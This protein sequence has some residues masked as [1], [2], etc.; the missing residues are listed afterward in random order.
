MLYLILSIFCSVLVGVVFKLARPKGFDAF[1]VI[2][3]NYA[4]AL[5]LC[6]LVFKPEVSAFEAG[7]PWLLYGGLALLLPGV[8]FLL[9]Q[10]IHFTGIVRTDAA[11][12]LSLFIPILAAWLVFGEHF[13]A[14]KT[15]G[16]VCAFTALFL[17]MGKK[18]EPGGSRG[19]YYPMLVLLGYGIIDLMFKALS[20]QTDIPYSTSLFAIFAMALP[21]AVGLRFMAK[22]GRSKPGR[23]LLLGM[24]I[25]LLN[26]G[27]I[28]SYLE[29][30]RHFSQS[31]STVFAGM[32]MGVILL[33]TAVGIFGFG[34][35]MHPRNYAGLA[36][37]L[38]SVVLI[39]ASQMGCC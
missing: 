18:S 33:G 31:P 20:K 17:L 24:V 1:A 8:F 12:R 11:Q 25:G 3:W 35:K 7:A 15:A 26:F 5:L 28:L 10:S 19:R 9:V 34:E 6:A 39:V 37:A 4:A 16:I 30:H 29:A 38:V 36:L 32:N 23:D 21:V 14:V 13:S 2:S 22:T 27:N